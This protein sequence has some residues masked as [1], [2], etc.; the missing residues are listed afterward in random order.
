MCDET[1]VA[2]IPRQQEVN[3]T[4]E[5]A[6]MDPSSYESLT[7]PGEHNT[8]IHQLSLSR[9]SARNIGTY[10]CITP[11]GSKQIAVEMYSEY[12][13]SDWGTSVINK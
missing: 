13:L 9:A 7:Y 5:G 3:W 11:F 4:F 1:L 8:T 10:Q 6:V 12:I 2:F